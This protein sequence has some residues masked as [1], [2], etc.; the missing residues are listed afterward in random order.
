MAK[1]FHNESV[2][3]NMHL[4]EL[5]KLLDNNPQFNFLIRT[6]DRPQAKQ[7]ITRLILSTDMAHHCK[8]LNALKESRERAQTAHDHSINKWV[9]CL[10]FSS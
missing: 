10:G 5:W 6:T 2:L 1:Q 4:Q 9:H 7:I 8:S 3:E